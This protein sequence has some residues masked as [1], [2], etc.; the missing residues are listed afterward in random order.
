MINFTWEMVNH[1]V[2]LTARDVRLIQVF[3]L[4]KD[5]YKT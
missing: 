4:F 3:T 2:H 5:L 1:H